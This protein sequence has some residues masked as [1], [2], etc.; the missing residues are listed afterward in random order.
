MSLAQSAGYSTQ[1]SVYLIFLGA[2]ALLCGFPIIF[3]DLVRENAIT[4]R[5]WFECL[6]VGLFW[7]MELSAAAAVTATMLASMC[8]AGAQI[9]SVDT[10]TST[11]V[12][13]AFT[14]LCAGILLIYLVAL[15][16]S[17]II[18]HSADSQIWHAT[19]KNYSWF[20]TRSS[21]CSAPPSPLV[22]KSVSVVAPQP[23]PALSAPRQT[24]MFDS[25]T[26]YPPPVHA[27]LAQRPPQVPEFVHMSHDYAQQPVFPLA[28]SLPPPPSNQRQPRE[29]PRLTIVPSLYP[30][31]LHS[32]ITPSARTSIQ[33]PS[34]QIEPS[35]LGDWPRKSMTEQRPRRR[36]PS[37]PGTTQ[38]TSQL[39]P[40]LPERS[41]EI[42]SLAPGETSPPRHPR[43]PR[44]GHDSQRLRNTHRPPPLNL[45][46]ISSMDR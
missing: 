8:S 37:A 18:H 30:Q 36:P 1:I 21:I 35:P 23:R 38:A 26:D 10:C 20:A 43:G 29:V 5:I 6:W 33:R 15:T 13:M 39:P 42:T 14:W 12:L 16:A 17:A 22:E 40:A 45:S 4:S 25:N 44:A 7:V 19:A 41:G 27:T 28:P 32:S 24:W 9:K 46:G 11:R 34:V 2:F 3:I 31:H